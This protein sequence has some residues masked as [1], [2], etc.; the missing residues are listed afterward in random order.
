MS[1]IVTCFGYCLFHILSINTK[2]IL[3]FLV[4]LKSNLRTIKAPI[5]KDTIQSL[6]H[7]LKAAHQP[8]TSR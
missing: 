3:E 6:E 1:Y 5:L 8:T 7:I 4:K 2:E